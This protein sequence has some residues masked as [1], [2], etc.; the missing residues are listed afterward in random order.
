IIFNLNKLD[1]LED[2]LVNE[3]NLN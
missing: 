1:K 3:I 2:L